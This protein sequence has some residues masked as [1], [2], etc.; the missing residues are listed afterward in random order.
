MA[1]FIGGVGNLEKH[2]LIEKLISE[3]MIENNPFA[4]FPKPLIEKALEVIED[5]TEDS[6]LD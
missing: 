2:D 6:K 4:V 1:F 3:E 5:F